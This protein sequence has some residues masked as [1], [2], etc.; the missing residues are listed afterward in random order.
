M[1]KTLYSFYEKLGG[2]PKKFD[3]NLEY[4]GSN[5]QSEPV[6]K[7]Y[8]RGFH[9]NDYNHFLKPLIIL[10]PFCILSDAGLLCKEIFLGL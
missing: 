10:H 8:D 5:C 1:L 2:V 4:C 6:Y 7:N 9:Y 3:K